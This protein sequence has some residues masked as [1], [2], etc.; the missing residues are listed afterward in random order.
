MDVSDSDEIYEFDETFRET[1]EEEKE[2]EEEEEEEVLGPVEN[3]DSDEYLEL[4][5]SQYSDTTE[6]DEAENENQVKLGPKDENH[7]N[8]PENHQNELKNHENELENHENELENGIRPE[9]EKQ[10]INKPKKQTTLRSK[11]KSGP[12]NLPNSN[13]KPNSKPK[14]N[15]NFNPV[16]TLSFELFTDPDPSKNSAILFY[17]IFNAAAE[18]ESAKKYDTL[19]VIATEDW[20]PT[21]KS[22]KFKKFVLADFFKLRFFP[23]PTI[24]GIYFIQSVWKIRA[25]VQIV[26]SWKN[27]TGI[28]HLHQ[29]LSKCLKD[30]GNTG[31]FCK[32]VM[33]MFESGQK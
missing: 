12:S 23:D 32:N 10:A 13:S 21:L 4:A 11:S 31:W 18:T 5:A 6:P 17:Y 28:P 20:A 8:E 16:Y 26:I 33:E 3:Q 14:Y 9:V 22:R 7:E 15:Q 30:S 19:N 1:D 2:E 29:F 25:D 24:L 27:S